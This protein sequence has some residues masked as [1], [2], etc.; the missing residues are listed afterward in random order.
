MWIKILS[1]LLQLI[2]SSL[3]FE[4]IF[5]AARIMNDGK[6]AK[7]KLLLSFDEDFLNLHKKF[8][9]RFIKIDLGRWERE[10][11]EPKLLMNYQWSNI[12]Q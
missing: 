8:S 9:T 3:N 4:Y 7:E 2:Y 6:R 11:G 5:W 1:F 10:R 12:F